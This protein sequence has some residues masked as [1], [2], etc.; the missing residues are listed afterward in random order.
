LQ[1]IELAEVG[2]HGDLRRFHLAAFA[3]D[4]TL[5]FHR[6]AGTKEHAGSH[7]RCSAQSRCRTFIGDLLVATPHRILL[8][9]FFEE[10]TRT[11]L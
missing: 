3:D 1:T 9:G 4:E 6:R 7:Y 5:R 2:A 11:I 10:L 8:N